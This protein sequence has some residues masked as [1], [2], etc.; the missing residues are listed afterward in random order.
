MIGVDYVE[1]GKVAHQ[2]QR[3]HGRTAYL[4]AARLAHEAEAEGKT[5]EAEFW[6]AVSASLRPR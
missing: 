2:L 1:V 3:D 5:A 6:N 4:Y